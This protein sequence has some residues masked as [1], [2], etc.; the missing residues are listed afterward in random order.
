MNTFF[1]PAIEWN[2]FS[3]SFEKNLSLFDIAN[4][5]EV[6]KKAKA[7]YFTIIKDIP[8]F[9]KNGILLTTLL[10]ATI[11]A[12]VYLSLPQRFGVKLVEEYYKNSMNNHVMK[13][14]LRK[15][16]NFKKGYQCNLEKISIRSQK[17]T[18]PY[19][20]RFKFVK[21]KT[22]DSYDAIFDKCGICVLYKQL[23]IFEIVPALCSYDYDMAKQTNSI[24]T[25][26]FRLANGDDVCDCHYEKR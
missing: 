25:R 22:L 17:A 7:K 14:M 2:L 9:R 13:L 11:L 6:M 19:T 16:K 10:N 23:G 1:V 15:N 21:G 24:F 20:W 18:N 5:K 26:A 3:G 12:S 8:S 4:P